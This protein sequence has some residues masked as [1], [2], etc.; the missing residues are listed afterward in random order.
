MREAARLGNI[1]KVRECFVD[2]TVDVNEKDLGGKTAL[3]YACMYGKYSTATLLLDHGADIEA[4][5]NNC[6][7]TPLMCACIN[8]RTSIRKLLLD[9]IEAVMSML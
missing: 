8:G 2:D 5:T 7:S 1:D 6:K 9:R 4:V 3:H